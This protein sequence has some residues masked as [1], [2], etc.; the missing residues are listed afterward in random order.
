[1]SA[2]CV[3]DFDGDGKQDLFLAQNV[4]AVHPET[5]RFDAGR[6]LLLRGQGDGRFTAVPGQESGILIY[7]EQLNAASCDYNHD[8][9]VD[10]AVTQTGAQTRLYKNVW[11]Q[12][13]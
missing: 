5:S 8:G 12:R 10:L 2:I 3:A 9:R 13:K 11:A 1:V 7:G 4:F 6:G